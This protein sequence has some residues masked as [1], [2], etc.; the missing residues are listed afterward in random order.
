MSALPEASPFEPLAGWYPDPADPHGIRLWD[1]RAW[2][3]V[4][5]PTIRGLWW[6]R[7]RDQV[8][9]DAARGRNSSAAAAAAYGALVTMFG[10]VAVSYASAG[11][12][13]VGL[14][15]VVPVSWTLGAG[16]VARRGLRYAPLTGTGRTS[17]RVGLGLTLLGLGLSVLGF[18]L[19]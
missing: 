5:G 4:T 2:S 13:N 11:T 1:G 3:P 8:L 6:R 18:V 7:R 10:L 14:G 12:W 9:R 16:I 15:V 17:A 19:R